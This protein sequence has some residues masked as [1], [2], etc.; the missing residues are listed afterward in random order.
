MNHWTQLTSVGK[1]TSHLVPSTWPYDKF[2]DTP[3]L[4][5]GTTVTLIDQDGPGVV[6]CLHVS[7][8]Y[9]RRSILQGRRRRKR[10]C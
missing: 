8:Y 10:W 4:N 3:E 9:D 1:A 2:P 6:S 7:D 5:A